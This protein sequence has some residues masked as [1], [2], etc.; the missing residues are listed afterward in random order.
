M[1]NSTAS[2]GGAF[3]AS[4]SKCST[5][6][7]TSSAHAAAAHERIRVRSSV[8]L[9]PAHPQSDVSLRDRQIRTR[10]PQTENTNTRPT[11]FT[12]PRVLYDAIVQPFAYAQSAVEPTYCY[13]QTGMAIRS[14]SPNFR[15]RGD[16][17]FWLHSVN[18][19][20]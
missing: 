14:S 20:L 9:R 1:R 11:L 17:A 6:V 5:R 8:G 16:S 15:T 12:A 19:L 4:R 7:E 3:D 18:L 13:L 2:A 10:P